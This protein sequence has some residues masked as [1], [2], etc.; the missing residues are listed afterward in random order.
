[1][2]HLISIYHEQIPS[3][4]INSK[5]KG[6]IETCISVTQ[7]QNLFRYTIMWQLQCM[8]CNLYLLSIC[9][10]FDWSFM[11]HL[12]VFYRQASSVV[13]LNR[14][15]PQSGLLIHNSR[16]SQPRLGSYANCISTYTVTLQCF[17]LFAWCLSK[18]IRKSLFSGNWQHYTFCKDLNRIQLM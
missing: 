18:P 2:W 14:A 7:K 6:F 9:L 15:E 16:G 17:C 8:D 4:N 10:S 3:T 5:Q 1:M 11:L 13:G 12:R